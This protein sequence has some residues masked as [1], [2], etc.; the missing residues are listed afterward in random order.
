MGT[1]TQN[2]IAPLLALWKQ[3][4]DELDEKII[5]WAGNNLSPNQ[6]NDLIGIVRNSISAIDAKAELTALAA[7]LT[8]PVTVN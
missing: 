8:Q 2:A 4:D 6:S 1:N 3:R 7:N 5:E